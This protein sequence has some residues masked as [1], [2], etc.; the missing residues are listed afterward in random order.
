LSDA[1][2]E[3]EKQL[4]E[5]DIQKRQG[6]L[7]LSSLQS[8]ASDGVLYATVAGEV[9]SVG[10]PE[11]YVQDG[12]AFLVVSGDSGL[13]VKGTISELLLDDITVGTT[14]TANSWETGNTFEATITEIGDYP[15]S[16]N[17]WGDGNPNVSYYSYI[18]RI[19]D[20]LNLSNGEY[21]DLTIDT[22][23]SESGGIY[24]PKAYVRTEDGKSYCMIADENNKLKKQYI[25]TGKT[26]YGSAVEVKSGVSEEDR[27]AFP[28]G[29]TAVEGAAVKDAEDTYYY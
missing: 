15:V 8:S 22:N 23:Q 1:I 4:K 26:I 3:Q 29:K 19:D 18:A 9:K 6:E 2:R 14:V 12:S 13:Y 28:Y 11:N 27:I 10:D 24:L 7:E 5:L 20:D 25:A 21:V 16:G 17:S